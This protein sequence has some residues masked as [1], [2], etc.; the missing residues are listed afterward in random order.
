[1]EEFMFLGLR[2]IKGVSKEEFFKRFGIRMEEVYAPV[3]TKYEKLHM[4]NNADYVSLTEK[5]LDV[6]NV[7]MADFLL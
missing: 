2:T 4:L 3:L 5:G 6:S 7:I 1:M